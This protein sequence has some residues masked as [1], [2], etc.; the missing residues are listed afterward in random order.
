MAGILS[1]INTSTG[2]EGLIEPGFHVSATDEGTEEPEIVI[3]RG[4]GHHGL[5]SQLLAVSEE[6]GLEA[7]PHPSDRKPAA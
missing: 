6:G 5:R 4:R 1:L 3:H 2:E 7:R